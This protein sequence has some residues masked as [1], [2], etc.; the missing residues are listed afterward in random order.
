LKRERPCWSLS[1]S[2]S[3]VKAKPEIILIPSVFI[4]V[5]LLWELAA[6]AYGVEVIFPKLSSVGRAFIMALKQGVVWKNMWMTLYETLF[7]FFFGALL[8]LVFGTIISQLPL[9]EKV[10]Y[11]YIVAF[12][13]MPKVA[14]A[15]LFVVWFGFGVSSKVVMA[16]II[17]FFPILVNT[18]V[19][20]RSID[21]QKLDLLKSLSA[22]KS[23]T[24]R[25]V[26]L[27]NAL[28]F[29]MAGFEIGIV[30]SLLGAIVGEFIGAS[31]GG[32][33]HIILQYN[34]DLNTAS[35]FWVIILLSVIGLILNLVMLVI[36][37]K[38]VFWK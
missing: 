1:S 10:V 33:G 20:L 19:G 5:V 30:M 34:N 36:H 29:I 31:K 28:P 26:K 8:G 7:G 35:V 14:L 13:S 16:T 17:T 27:P 15:P 18:V 37:K 9:T 38:F 12:Q 22:T 6:G 2:Y 24:F 21:Q 4:L 3:F 25:L 11:P 32:L 23:Q